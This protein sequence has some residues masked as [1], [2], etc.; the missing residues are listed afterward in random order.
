MRKITPY[1]G[2]QFTAQY[3]LIK[4]PFYCISI[5]NYHCSH[6]APFGAL[7][8]KELKYYRT[9]KCSENRALFLV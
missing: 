5:T 2:V 7:R 4:S 3:A 9:K 8:R 6:A 1:H